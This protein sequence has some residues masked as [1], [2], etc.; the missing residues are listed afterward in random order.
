MINSSVTPGLAPRALSF[1]A[2][3]RHVMMAA[4]CATIVLGL[5]CNDSIMAGVQR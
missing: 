4:R 1:F 3:A 2:D 5:A